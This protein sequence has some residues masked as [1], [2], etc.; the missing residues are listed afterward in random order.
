MKNEFKL[1]A[2][3]ISENFLEDFN[4]E[5]YL[6][7]KDTWIDELENDIENYKNQELQKEK[8]KAQIYFIVNEMNSINWDIRQ[9]YV[10]ELEQ[11]LKNLE[12]A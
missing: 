1:T 9:I 11:Q 12:D 3:K 2:R 6:K 10:E 5:N 8:I 7:Y 4:Y